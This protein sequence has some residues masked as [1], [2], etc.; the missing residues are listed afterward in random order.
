[1]EMKKIIY[2]ELIKEKY[3]EIIEGLILNYGDSVEKKCR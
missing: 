2:D 1:M 3:S